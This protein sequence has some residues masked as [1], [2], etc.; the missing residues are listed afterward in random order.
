MPATSP[1][2]SSNG[3][4][5]TLDPTL[6]AGLGGAAVAYG[7]LIRRAGGQVVVGR[8]AV[9]RFAAGLAVIGVALAP[10]IE[11]AAERSIAAH[12]V[13]HQLLVLV[14]APLLASGRA[15]TLARRVTGRPLLPARAGAAERAVGAVAAAVLHL[16]V[17][18][19]WHVPAAYDAALASPSVHQAEHLTMLA[20]GVLAWGAILAA[21]RDDRAVLGSVLGLAVLAV[22]GAVLGVVLLASPV[23]LYGWYGGAGLDDQR[24]AGALMKVGA[25]VVYAGAA[26]GVVAA[27]LR[28]LAA[29][30]ACPVPVPR[31]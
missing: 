6:L 7:A 5:V 27:W 26:I 17:L 2:S 15:L 12:M 3:D 9:W 23:A 14:A 24:V 21:R 18:L 1:P 25:L 10:A 11:R 4:A 19:A 31:S 29:S 16:A 22:G 28:S 20:T 8:A 30:P 13:Q